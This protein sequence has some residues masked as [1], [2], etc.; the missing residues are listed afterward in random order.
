MKNLIVTI[1][2]LVISGFL[3]YYLTKDK[4]DV[5]YTLSEN[6]PLSFYNT[7]QPSENIQQ[8]EIKNSGDVLVKKVI[9]KI[10]KQ[11]DD[12]SLK[13]YSETDSVSVSK[14][15]GFEMNYPELPPKGSIKLILKTKDNIVKDEDIEIYDDKGI[16]YEAFKESNQTSYWSSILA[17]VYIILIIYNIYNS[18]VDGI[19]SEYD[20][21]EKILKR[22]KPFFV[23]NSKWS[24]FR[25]DAIKE[26]FKTD[27][28]LYVKNSLAAKILQEEKDS[29]IT[30]NEWIEIVNSAQREY[31]K[32]L[33][34]ECLDSY[35][36]MKL[37]TLKKPRNI[38]SLM[39]DE[40][41]SSIS[42]SYSV[43]KIRELRYEKIAVIQSF[44]NSDKPQNISKK[45]WDSLMEKVEDILIYRLVYELINVKDI[46]SYLESVDIQLI[47]KE[48]RNKPLEI[49]KKLLEIN[50][51]EAVY[52]RLLDIAKGRD[53]EE[54]KPEAISEIAWQNLKVFN[55]RI[56]EI[57]QKAEDELTLARKI[58]KEL[59]PLKEKITKQLSIIDSVLNDPEFINKIESYN[60]DFSQG[61]FSN[62]RRISS[63]NKPL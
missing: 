34:R 29:H 55:N 2:G 24:E 26:L 6:I 53:I 38:E 33:E 28:S 30:E 40:I 4:I 17:V 15:S 63:L 8:L 44:L 37:L 32:L 14:K 7:N 51:F 60:D 19:N 18:I 52:E 36:I 56:K 11:I 57:K 12:Y 3:V 41:I 43:Y 23:T 25:K 10:D 35:D 62:L 27:Y 42:K 59:N 47:D 46:M 21:F 54:I 61:N 13:K 50:E 9:I 49:A 48:K 31:R 16:V 20:P 22:G 39:W 45:E 1:L 5:R 58:Q